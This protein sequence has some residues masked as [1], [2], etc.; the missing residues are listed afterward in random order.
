M[1]CDLS[2]KYEAL[3][4]R[5][6][7]CLP[8]PSAIM[9]VCWHI[10]NLSGQPRQPN[11]SSVITIDIGASY[12][13]LLESTIF[14]LWGFLLLLIIGHLELLATIIAMLHPPNGPT[15]CTSKMMSA[16]PQ[17]DSYRSLPGTPLGTDPRMMNLDL[18]SGLDQARYGLSPGGYFDSGT[19]CGMSP[20][21]PR[22]PYANDFDPEGDYRYN[23]SRSPGPT[24][25]SET[26]SASIYS[27]VCR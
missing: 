26:N 19:R 15:P 23:P 21:R 22:T 1:S 11:F 7:P 27:T 17:H 4:L 6:I 5:K 24:H 10:T 9:F 3:D 2:G 8:L 14:V 12:L 16:H 18:A 20:M 25:C 13:D